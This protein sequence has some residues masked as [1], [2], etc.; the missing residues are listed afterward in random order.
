M[1]VLTRRSGESIMINV[2]GK[3][4]KVTALVCNR[5]KSQIRLGFSADKNVIID[6]EEIYEQRKLD[7][8]I[9]ISA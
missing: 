2:D 1:L 9:S 3:E 6:R 4:I 7:G 5:S 8:S